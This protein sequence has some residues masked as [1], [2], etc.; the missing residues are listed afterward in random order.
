MVSKLLYY[1]S[2]IHIRSIDFIVLNFDIFEKFIRKIIKTKFWGCRCLSSNGTFHTHLF[3]AIDLHW[4]LWFQCLL[5]SSIFTFINT[6]GAGKFWNIYKSILIKLNYIVRNFNK[7]I[8]KEEFK[9]QIHGNDIFWNEKC[10]K[11]DL[12]NCIFWL[13]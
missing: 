5:W 3:V 9:W 8:R 2:N 1:N 10:Y 7:Q 11:F 12:S 13:V 6:V 4:T